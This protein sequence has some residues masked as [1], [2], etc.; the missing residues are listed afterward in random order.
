MLFNSCFGKKLLKSFCR[1][2]W[3]KCFIYNRYT[4]FQDIILK[5]CFT[6]WPWPWWYELLF[7]IYIIN[8]NL[9]SI[10]EYVPNS[11]TCNTFLV[12]RYEK[13]PL[14][15]FL[16]CGNYFLHHMLLMGIIL[17]PFPLKSSGCVI[18]RSYFK[19]QIYISAQREVKLRFNKHVHL[20][21]YIDMTWW[22]SSFH[23]VSKI[24]SCIS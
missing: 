18:N 15:L 4:L 1:M 13:Y 12:D 8:I 11:F 19:N 16:P 2:Y 6:I 21:H 14:T 9:G 20:Y 3:S 5:N 10:A 24:N 22:Q 17:Q 23:F 7:Y